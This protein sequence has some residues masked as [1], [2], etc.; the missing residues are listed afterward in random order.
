M[1]VGIDLLIRGKIGPGFRSK[2]ACCF[3]MIGDVL[4]RAKLNARML[5]VAVEYYLVAICL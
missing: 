3:F 5:P 4:C 2:V 1:F